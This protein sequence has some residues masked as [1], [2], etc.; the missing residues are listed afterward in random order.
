M[1]YNV[2]SMLENNEKLR[3]ALVL[4]DRCLI[5]KTVIRI[6]ADGTLVIPKKI[7]IGCFNEE[8]FRSDVLYQYG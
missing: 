7:R 4:L 3:I 5:K 2:I 1:S 8:V 6:G